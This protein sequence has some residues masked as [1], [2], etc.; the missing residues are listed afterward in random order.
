MKIFA[1]YSKV[2]LVSGPEWYRDVINHYGTGYEVHITLK[3]PCFV[4]ED[5]ILKIKERLG[6]YF[7][8]IAQVKDRIEL[9]FNTL[10][11]EDDI[12][13]INA[14]I[15][16]EIINLQK[17]LVNLLAEYNDFIQ[18]ELKKYQEHFVPHITLADGVSASEI[19]EIKEKIGDDPI[20]V[21][22]IEDVTLSVVNEITPEEA[23]NPN[24]KTIYFL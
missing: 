20:I 12:V 23:S 5:D 4:R 2:K 10:I 3:Q 14:E 22:D 6:H 11:V 7:E 1:I 13:M 16:V 8:E 17:D 18:P 24:N 9:Q 21:G 19:E 15:N